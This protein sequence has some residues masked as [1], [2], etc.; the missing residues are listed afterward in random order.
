MPDDDVP[1]PERSGQA[2]FG[3]T[4]DRD[5][6]DTEQRGQVHRAGV[7]GHQQAAFAQLDD[8]IIERRLPNAVDALFAQR[9]GDDL[10]DLGIRGGAEENPL[11]QSLP[12]DRS[13]DFR[14]PF[15]EPALR[16]PIFSPGTQP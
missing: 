15:G 14:E 3:G 2:I 4:K 8:E 10:A 5:D 13:R 6:R 1:A 16:G 9:P 11:H 12:R 7:V